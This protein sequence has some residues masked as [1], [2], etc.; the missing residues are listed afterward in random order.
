MRIYGM[1]SKEGH[2]S[3]GLW[4]GTLALI[5][6]LAYSL[7]FTEAT[8]LVGRSLSDSDSKTGFQ[9]AITPPWEA[10]LSL[11]I[12]GLTAADFAASWYEFGFGRAALCVI[13]LFVGLLIARR[14]LPKPDS[15]HFK[16][17][18]IRSMSNRYADYVRDGDQ[19]RGNMMKM[20]LQRAGV[21]AA[22]LSGEVVGD[23]PRTR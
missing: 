8:L 15:P 1:V 23:Q 17:V 21:D 20:L 6:L 14:I 4:I 19:V 16:V 11:V 13:A 9:D 2:V 10:K 12:Y 22:S 5:P 7:Q 3:I 18:I